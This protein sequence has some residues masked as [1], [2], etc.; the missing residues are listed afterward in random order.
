MP[1]HRSPRDREPGWSGD[2]TGLP[3]VASDE[4]ATVEGIRQIAAVLLP[5]KFAVDEMMT[6]LRIWG[7]EFDHVHEHDPIEHVS[8]RIKRPDAIIAKLRRRGL[9]IAPDSA[10]EHLD[11]L[12]G[13]RVV[14]PFVP[15][16]YL[17]RDLIGRHDVDIVQT[18]DYIAA[19]KPNGYRSL[20][21]ITK[22]P[23][24]LS[25]RTERVT[26]E[27]QLRTIAMDFW[28]AVEHEL[29]YKSGGAVAPDFFA[30]LKAAADTA[31][32]LDER[33]R[34]LHER[35]AAHGR[36]LPTTESDEP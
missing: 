35:A 30:E 32:D 2:A 24:S 36:E 4:L 12:A 21:L 8:S 18:K 20:H 19:P 15:D 33:M 22:V 13:V 9:P 29:L 14:C 23:V 1:G 26:V 3:T 31:A 11:D 6:K 5:Y 7:E 25:D 10:R 34:A 16:V 17:V 27:V 28:A